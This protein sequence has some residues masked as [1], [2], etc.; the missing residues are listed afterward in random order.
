MGSELVRDGVVPAARVE[1]VAGVEEALVHA[2]VPPEDADA[3]GVDADVDVE[4]PLG[5]AVQ[6]VS[7]LPHLEVGIA[8]CCPA[9]REERTRIK[10]P[11]RTLNPRRGDRTKPHSSIHPQFKQN[12]PDLSFGRTS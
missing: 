11:I 7:V 9:I 3:A 10:D 6:P 1:L 4:E 5:L 12:H 8:V 2:A